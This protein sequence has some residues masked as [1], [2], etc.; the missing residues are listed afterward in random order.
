MSIS[1]RVTTEIDCG[2][3]TSGVSVF[4]PVALCF[5]AIVAAGPHADSG[6]AS[7]AAELVTLMVSS[8]AGAVAAPA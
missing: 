1:S 3:F 5:A 6:A 7:A 8:F 2:V 4:V